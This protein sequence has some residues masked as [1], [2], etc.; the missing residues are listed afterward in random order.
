L[1]CSAASSNPAVADSNEPTA[2]QVGAGFKAI[3]SESA[4]V[5]PTCFKYG[6]ESIEH[7][8]PPREVSRPVEVKKTVVSLPLPQVGVGLHFSLAFIRKASR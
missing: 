8:C 2:Q 1:E 6:D 7:V 5:G 4:Q 3:R